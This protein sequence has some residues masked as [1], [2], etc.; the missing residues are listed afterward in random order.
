MR[1]G[2]LQSG[3]YA[4]PVFLR[5]LRQFGFRNLETSELTFGEGVTAIVGANA[6][7]KSNLLDASYLASSGDLPT[8]RLGD[9][10]RWGQ[11]EGFVAAQVERRG[12]DRIQLHVGLAPGKKVIRLDEQPARVYDVARVSAAVRITPEDADMIHGGPSL[13]RGWLDDV[14]RRLSR[15]YGA[16]LREYA[17]VLEQRN[18][19]LRADVAASYL[20]VFSD[21]LAV[22][23]DEIEDLR[24]RSL[25]RIHEVARLVYHEVGGGKKEL[26][27]ALEPSQGERPLRDALITSA[28]EERARGVTVVGPHRDDLAV[29][30]DGRSVQTFGSRG[31]A[32][33]AAM[34]LRVAE[35]RLLEELHGEPPILLLDDFSAELDAD[36]RNYLLSLSQ[37]LPQALVSGTEPPP[38]ATRILKIASGVVTEDG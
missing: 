16:L 13:R 15:R 5:S 29:Q 34:A 11:P 37:R 33:T 25:V 31:E 26:S 19:G 22:L 28:A 6:A 21:R 18:A 30:L 12:G 36:R 7:G 32:R 14:L 35:L 20:D 10:L 38:H 17:K 9:A 24:A 8:G 2:R 27:V 1:S 3:R 23:G 4:T